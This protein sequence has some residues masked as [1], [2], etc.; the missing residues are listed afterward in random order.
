MKS[1]HDTCAALIKQIN[2]GLERGANNVLREEDLTIMQVAVMIELDHGESETRSLKELEHRFGVA[3]PTMLG[4]VRRLELKG[5]LETFQSPEDK[6]VKLV[7]LTDEGKRKCGVGYANME[8]AEQSL[9]SA[10]SAE[11]QELFRD[12]LVRVKASLK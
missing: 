2:D 9:L 3:Q 4:I 5:F 8:T 1:Y 6:R 12:M 7:R 10:L 11:E